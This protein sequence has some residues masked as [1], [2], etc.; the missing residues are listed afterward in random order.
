VVYET[1][2]GLEISTETNSFFCAVRAEME[3]VVDDLKLKPRTVFSVRQELKL[4]KG[5]TYK[6]PKLYLL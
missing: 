5:S 3:E 1:V 4:K 6:Q 2:D